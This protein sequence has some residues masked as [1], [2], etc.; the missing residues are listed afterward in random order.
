[1]NNE[2]EKIKQLLAIIA[3]TKPHKIAS[4]QEVLG[5]LFFCKGTIHPTKPDEAEDAVHELADNPRTQPLVA[6][7]KAQ[8]IADEGPIVMACDIGMYLPQKN[9]QFTPLH[10]PGNTAKAEQQLAKNFGKEG[11][12]RVDGFEQPVIPVLAQLAIAI[13]SDFGSSSLPQQMLLVESIS[14][15]MLP[16]SCEQEIQEYLNNNPGAPGSNSGFLAQSKEMAKKIVAVSDQNGNMVPVTPE[17]YSLL[18]RL[19]LGGPN[20]IEQIKETLILNALA[21]KSEDVKRMSLISSAVTRLGIQHMF[22]GQTST[23]FLLQAEK[24][25]KRRLL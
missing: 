3:T 11:A 12:E 2:N 17:R 18:K 5:I 10:K 20:N 7:A 1:M 21:D 13:I 6:V 19:L 16:F 24:A 23:P 9:Q 15:F 22:D 25:Q 8:S 4:I 14:F